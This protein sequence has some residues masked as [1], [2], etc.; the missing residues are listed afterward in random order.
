[1]SFVHIGAGSSLGR[2]S[3]KNPRRPA[4]RARSYSE[5]EVRRMYGQSRAVK[6]YGRLASLTDRCRPNADERPSAVSSPCF[7]HHAARRWAHRRPPPASP[8]GRRARE[9]RAPRDYSLVYVP[10]PI[11]VHIVIVAVLSRVSSPTDVKV[12]PSALSVSVCD[13]TVVTSATP[14][15]VVVLQ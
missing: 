6:T 13:T 9:A 1:M 11:V 15:S 12:L 3:P 5:P 8:T 14:P 7:D 4:P 10:M 2:S